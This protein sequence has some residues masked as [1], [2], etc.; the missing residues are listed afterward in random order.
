LNTTFAELDTD[1]DEK[2]TLEEFTENFGKIRGHWVKMLGHLGKAQVHNVAR[3]VL[4][5]VSH[6]KGAEMMCE[7]LSKKGES[8]CK[9]MIDNQKNS[10]KMALHTLQT[11]AERQ[12]SREQ[13]KKETK[14]KADQNKKIRDKAEADMNKKQK[15]DLKEFDKMDINGDGSVDIKEIRKRAGSDKRAQE[16]LDQADTDKNGE[17]NFQEFLAVKGN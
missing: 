6:M 1:G 13:E 4:N 12:V 10:L 5:N 17:V 3:M 11:I 15:D 7:S 8:A 9:D 2:L 16:M 14:K